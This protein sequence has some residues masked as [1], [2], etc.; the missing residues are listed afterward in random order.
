MPILH[1]PGFIFSPR[2]RGTMAAALCA[3]SLFMAGCETKPEFRP[4]TS[5]VPP[6]PTFVTVP[7]EETC[8]AVEARYALGQALDP[9]LLEQMRTRTG[10]KSARTSAVGAPLPSPA[11]PG[12]LNVDVDPQGRISG[13]RCG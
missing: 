2:A 3:A 13:A 12:R 11:D 1:R 4:L 6:P 10:S 8:Q 7:S 5:E 9:L